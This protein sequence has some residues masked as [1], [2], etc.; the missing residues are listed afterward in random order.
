MTAS[1]TTAP[2]IPEAQPLPSAD[3]VPPTGIAGDGEEE[4]PR[5]KRR[6]LIL[7]LLL[8]IL[9]FLL[10][11]AI[12]YLLFRQPVPLPPIPATQVPHFTTAFYGVE[13]PTGVAVNAAGDRIYVTQSGSNRV[14]VVLDGSGNKLAEMLPPVSTGTDHAPVYVAIDPLTSEVYVTDRPTG[15]IYIYDAAG[16]FQRQFTPAQPSAGWQPLAVAFDKAGLLYVSNL[17]GE[18]PT[19]EVYD[20]EGAL[21]RTLGAA[22][23]M[24]F[25]NGIAV[26]DAGYVYVTD[27]NNG[28]LLVFDTDGN[29][30]GRVGRG[31]GAGN[32]G[33]PRGV[34]LDQQDHVFVM[35]TSGQAG[36]VYKQLQP[37]EDSP[38]YVGT[39]GTQGVSN[40]EFLYPNGLA[41]DGRGRLF[42]ADTSNG[43]IQLWNY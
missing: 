12:W 37:G 8:G 4:D 10:G 11:L 38:E 34:A 17:T 18:T 32:L 30:A 29:V 22:E 20:R 27:S 6:A 9:A 31:A 25:P 5:R 39:F 26:D 40:G 33:L 21:V 43:R 14:A 41:V 2:S 19:I 3:E 35:D 24:N 23:N 7:L 42:V 15:D 36:F 16:T 1:P 13:R 28:R